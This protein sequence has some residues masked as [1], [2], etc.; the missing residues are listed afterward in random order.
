[1]DD[2]TC[3]LVM[4]SLLK[5]PN[6]KPGINLSIPITDFGELFPG[7][8]VIQVLPVL[9]LLTDQGVIKAT[10]LEGSC[11]QIFMP[12]AAFGYFDAKRAEEE[13]QSKQKWDERKWNLKVSLLMYVL[14]F[15]SG[16][17]SMWIKAKFF[18]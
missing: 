14:G 12:A 17:A 2:K 3:D 9:K 8:S 1:M 16:I 4:S 10:N 13:R 5:F 7:L 15:I 18:P 11:V 6:N